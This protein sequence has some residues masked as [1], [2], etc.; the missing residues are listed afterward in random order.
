MKTHSG[1]WLLAL[2]LFLNIRS[3]SAQEVIRQ[4][5]CDTRPYQQEIDS[6]DYPQIAGLVNDTVFIRFSA[7]DPDNYEVLFDRKFSR[8]ALHPLE[9]QSWNDLPQ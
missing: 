7:V 1:K 2:I 4:E 8:D 5:A 3:G 6:E 9:A